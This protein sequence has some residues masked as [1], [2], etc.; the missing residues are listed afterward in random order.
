MGFLFTSAHPSLDR[1]LILYTLYSSI[2]CRHFALT[3][4]FCG[5]RK[6]LQAPISNGPLPFYYCCNFYEAMFDEFPVNKC[7]SDVADHCGSK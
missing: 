7:I 6:M 1:A 5:Q 4:T 2:F 3:R